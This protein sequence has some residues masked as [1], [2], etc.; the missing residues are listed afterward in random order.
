MWEDVV[1]LF[2]ANAVVEIK[3]EDPKKVVDVYLR[4]RG[5]GTQVVGIERKW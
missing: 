2:A 5:G 3:G 4:R 1:D